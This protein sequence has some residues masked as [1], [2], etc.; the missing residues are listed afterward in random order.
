MR[1]KVITHLMII[2][3][4][5]ECAR[6][7]EQFFSTKHLEDIAEWTDDAIAMLKEQDMQNVVDMRLSKDWFR[8]ASCPRCNESLEWVYHR[9]Y[10]GY[11]GQAV[12]WE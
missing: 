1:E 6:E 4:W 9:N 7:R 3:A 11:C 10:C 2:H 5:A 12:K 8:I